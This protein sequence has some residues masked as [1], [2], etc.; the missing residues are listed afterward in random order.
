MTP[1]CIPKSDSKEYNDDRRIANARFD[2]KP[3]FICHCTKPDD[4]RKALEKA[5]THNPKLPVRIRSGGHHHEGMCSGDGVLMIDVTNMSYVHLENN[6]TT[7][8]IGAGTRLCDVY[9]TLMKNGRILPGGGCGDVRVGGLVQGGGWGPYSRMHG[10]TCDK[11]REVTMVP[12]NGGEAI[13]VTDATDSELMRAIRGGGGGNFGVITEYVFDV[14]AVGPITEFTIKFPDASK[15]APAVKEWRKSFHLADNRLT[16]FCRVTAPGS[17]DPPL[18]VAGSFLG[19]ETDLK[20]ILPKL[21]TYDPKNAS[22]NPAKPDCTPHPEYQPGPVLED[23]APGDLTTTC[24]GAFYPHKVSSTFPSTIFGD[25]A[26]QLAVDYVLGSGSDSRARRYLSLHG[27]GG[28]IDND[29]INSC[30]AFRKKPFMLQYQAWWYQAGVFMWEQLYKS[31]IREFRKLLSDGAWT[32]G[33]F[34]NFPDVELAADRKALLSIY[35]GGDKN[36]DRL[37]AVKARHDIDNVLDFP[38]GI[39]PK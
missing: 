6:N 39:P 3:A 16:S 2:Y 26:V 23:A 33:S 13:P 31:W 30:F 7:A 24:N 4:V 14:P 11:L 9:T 22:F 32:E 34:I 37:I 10:M 8:R 15:A 35:Y 17:G 28:A 19:T 20:Q 25:T 18:V 5:R 21:L 38:M 12:A 36:L 29:K 27:M 1:N